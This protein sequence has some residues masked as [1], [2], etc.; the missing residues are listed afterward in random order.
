MYHTRDTIGW[1]WHSLHL[2]AW[3]IEAIIVFGTL[4]LAFANPR[5]GSRWLRMAERL[6]GSLASRRRLVL[7]IIGLTPLLIRA[8]LLPILG[9]PEPYIHDE[10]GYLLAADTFASGRLTNPTHPMWQHFESPYII[11]QPTYMSIYPPAQGMFLAVGLIIGGHPWVGV[12]LSVGLMCAAICWMLQAWVPPGWALLGSGL[13][14]IRLG[15]LTYWMNSY[16][17]GAV[18]AIGGALVLGALPRITRKPQVRDALLFGLG[19]VILANS[20]PYFGLLFSLPIG[21]A[22]LFWLL[23]KKGVSAQLKIRHVLL[24]LSLLLIIAAGAM[25]FYFWRI[26]GNPFQMPREVYRK[27]Y[28]LAPDF[29]LQPPIPQPNYRHQDMRNLQN[30]LMDIYLQARTIR[31]AAKWNLVKV[32]SLWKHYFGPALSL[33]LL[34]LPW[35]LKDRRIRFFL[36]VS[37]VMVVGISVMVHTMPHYVA[38]ITGLTIIFVVQAM[39]HLRLWCVRGKAT[40]LFL[41]RAVPVICLLM[42]LVRVGIQDYGW[43]LPADRVA[44]RSRLHAQLSQ[45][46]GRHLVF[47]SFRI[48]PHYR[49]AWTYNEADIDAA[50]IVWAQEMDATNNQ[51]LIKY[52]GDRRIWQAEPNKDAGPAHL[53]IYPIPF[54]MKQR[55]PL[56]YTIAFALARL[57][58]DAQKDR[59]DPNHSDIEFCISKWELKEGD[60]NSQGQTVGKAKRVRAVLTWAIEHSFEDG[61]GFVDQLVAMVR[62]Q[63]GFRAGSP[64]HVGEE[65]ITS[66]REAMASEGF[67][68]TSDGELRPAALE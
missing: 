28:G 30:G 60:P 13:L 43:G 15:V 37:A 52:F 53:P 24:P 18:A 35:V 36:L 49:H 45:Q 2:S 39:R 23:G 1:S 19:L 32:K 3:K 65:A 59:R 66:L 14:A 12:W 62:S 10:F 27:T 61:R 34:V 55:P 42:L 46:E 29:I 50:R 9:A 57:V 47:V 16:W 38:P 20:R 25:G 68:L 22:L 17:G 40:G 56:N 33:P 26:T 44:P 63:G 58:D 64:N 6:F 5:F 41:V 7:L 8:M 54:K 11:H 51:T 67:V 31:G 48:D 21:V 4:V